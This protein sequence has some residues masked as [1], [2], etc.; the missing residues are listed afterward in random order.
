MSPLQE[1]SS[2]LFYPSQNREVG[3]GLEI[4]WRILGTL[5]VL[6]DNGK[7]SFMLHED[8]EAT[9]QALMRARVTLGGS[10]PLSRLQ[11]LQKGVGGYDLKLELMS[12]SLSPGLTHS[13]CSVSVS[14]YC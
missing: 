9:R 8:K 4:P 3:L 13:K 5:A 1:P 7:K 6:G 2:P 11:L 14:H 12:S 10:R